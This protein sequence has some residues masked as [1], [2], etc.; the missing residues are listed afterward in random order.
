MNQARSFLLIAWLLVAFLAWEAWQ[1]DYAGPATKPAT[2]GAVE[3]PNGETPGADAL[4]AL[5][6]LPEA[7]PQALPDSGSVPSAQPA[8]PLSAGRLVTVNTDVLRLQVDTRGGS[9]VS[10]QL[11]DYRQS[12]DK[13][14]EPVTL[15]SRA[16]DRLFTAQSGLIGAVPGAASPTHQAELAAESD[17]Y[18]LAD[19]SDTLIVPLQ[20]QDPSGLSMTKRLVFT[21]GAYVVDV[22]HEL[23][24]ESTQPWR[25]NAYRQLLRV[26]PPKP[27]GSQFTNPEQYSFV[28]AAWYNPVDKFEKLT[29]DDFDEANPLNMN[30]LGGWTAMLQ[31]Y[32]FAAWIP[33][34][35]ESVQVSTTV[36]TGNQYL[37]R[38]VSP[39]F[40]LAA[41]SRI[42]HNA[43]LYVG[44]KLQD[45]LG[46]IAPGLER[47]V[48][49][50]VF[51]ILSRPLFW[52]LSKLHALFGNW[53]WAIIGLVV[54]IKL[55]FFK[56]SEAQYKS[57]AKMRAVQPRIEALKE[58]YGDDKQKFQMAMMELY[59][60]EKI[61]PMGGCLP[62]LVQI[63]VF[64][65]L[66]WV[67]L[68]SVELRHAPWILWIQNLT[69]RDPYFVL[70][71]INMATMYL[72]QLMTPMVGMDPMQKRIMQIM[73]L[74]FGFLFAFFPAGLVLYWATNGL[75]GLLQQWVITR[76]HGAQAKTPAKA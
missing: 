6:A 32:F 72:T 45:D 63:P 66:Y 73:P 10:V 24:N 55:A 22:Q 12:T 5:D 29:F 4:P 47:T 62:I 57:F 67:L 36:L 18:T 31:H 41:G 74:A 69:A 14:A 9:I 61:N 35:E 27:A 17:T 40:E 3:N 43:R 26:P 71:V 42:E 37:I 56:L 13:N 59:K 16:A 46:E 7:L 28:G 65:A 15:L 76:R 23:V 60:K 58:R 8:V 21:R 51:T 25:G 49:Y 1:K 39:A 20:W 30:Q 2:V 64:I 68:E 75:L 48:D 70:P 34:P 44:P 33:A 19:G 38:E 54:L 52:L 50:G 53:G 11:L